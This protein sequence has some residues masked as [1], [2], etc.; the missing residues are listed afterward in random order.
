MPARRGLHRS[1]TDLIGEAGLDLPVL[2]RTGYYL[3][4]L[5]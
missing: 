1:R 4:G 5:V 2:S 3:F